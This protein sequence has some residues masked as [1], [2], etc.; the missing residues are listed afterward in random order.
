M[1][2]QLYIAFKENRLFSDISMEDLELDEIKGNLISLQE[3]EIL[4]RE[5]DPSDAVYLVVSGEI[6]LIKKKLLGA[7]KAFV[8]GEND[9]FGYDEISD[10][11]ARTST[12]VAL[13]DTYLIALSRFEIDKIIEQNH[14]IKTNLLNYSDIS[15][16]FE[17]R[18]KDQFPENDKPEENDRTDEEIKEDDAADVAPFEQSLK[19]D[20][21][22]KH[23]T[24]IEEDT[25]AYEEELQEEK[26][27]KIHGEELSDEST[28]D[29][30]HDD[31]DNEPLFDDEEDKDEKEKLSDFDEDFYAVFSKL[32]QDND[33]LS[34][35]DQTG[36]DEPLA[37]DV[38]Q[39]DNREEQELDNIEKIDEPEDN[40]FE[41]ES[42]EQPADESYDT[43]ESEEDKEVTDDSIE[44]VEEEY[45]IPE[46]NLVTGDEEVEHDEETRDELIE[47]EENVDEEGLGEITE[48]DTFP[49]EEILEQTG[50]ENIYEDEPEQTNETI[51]GDESDTEENV[52]LSTEYLRKIIKASQSVNS[53]IKIDEV[54][55]NVVT[56]ATEL[57]DAERGTLYLIDKEKKELWSKIATGEE[58]REIHLKIGEGLAGW[59]AQNREL[60]NIED[61]AQDER[62]KADYDKSTG[63]NTKSVLCFPIKNREDEIVGV[64][65]L[66]NSKK[67]KFTELDEEFLNAISI[68]CALALQNAELVEKLLETERVSSLGKMTNFLIQDIKKPVLVSKRYAEHVKTK[69]LPEDAA[70]IIDMILDQLSQVADLVQTTSNYSEGKAVFRTSRTNLNETLQDYGDRLDSYVRTRNCE[71]IN[72]FD[73]DAK[74]NI[75]SKEM[76]QVY[77]HIIR[78]A[79]DAMPEGGRIFVSTKVENDNVKLLFKDEGMGIPESIVDKLFEPFMTHGKKNG[80]GLGLT[81]AKKIV[82]GHN[83]SIYVESMLGEGST[84]I[85]ELP[86]S[87]PF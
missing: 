62:F 75:D 48:E 14:I 43:A 44:D 41:F 56:A 17:N 3:G 18:D 23:D 10:D 49:E 46:E 69:D 13:R 71:I 79:C 26:Y 32:T 53:N 60:V 47:T 76:F 66:L 1:E 77:N 63:Y 5:G 83:G 12:A 38:S 59:V 54:L 78:N 82:Q 34:T 81:I 9:F 39:I 8:F 11:I 22:D 70:H 6:N 20:L 24:S 74:V 31:E 86:V 50:E 37:E 35:E 64:L 15:S 55:N 73:K 51:T 21:I 16:R 72:Q 4:F 85:I 67:G 57:T 33:D 52:P 58:I 36:E 27:E 2:K 68:Q 61:A 25:S 7:S 84:F 45:S 29:S 30:I 40:D 87:S 28:I 65:Q 80:T 19:D 42:D